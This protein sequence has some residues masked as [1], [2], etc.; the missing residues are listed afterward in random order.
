MV[1]LGGITPLPSSASVRRRRS[2]LSWSL[3][4][5]VL[6]TYYSFM[7]V[8]AFALAGNVYLQGLAPVLE[9]RVMPVGTYIGASESRKDGQAAGY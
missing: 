8:V 6:G 9:S 1:D 2:R 7:L 3:S 4:A 5:A